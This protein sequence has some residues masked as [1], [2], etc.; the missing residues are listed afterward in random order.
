[1]LGSSS[2]CLQILYLVAKHKPRYLKDAPESGPYHVAPDLVE[3][4]QS[5]HAAGKAKELGNLAHEIASAA[6]GCL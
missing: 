3:A 1:V 4:V 2:V 6:E 5:L